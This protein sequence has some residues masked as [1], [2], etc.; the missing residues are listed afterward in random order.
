MARSLSNTHARERRTDVAPAALL[1]WQTAKPGP[2][3]A[4]QQ[5]GKGLGRTLAVQ[6]LPAVGDYLR[7][8][9][10]RPIGVVS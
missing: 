5:L 6:V 8:G 10:A 4:F 9:R 1:R 7:D 3:Q 2:R